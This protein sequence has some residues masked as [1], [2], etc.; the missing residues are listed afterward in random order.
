ML[1]LLRLRFVRNQGHRK[2]GLVEGGWAVPCGQF[3]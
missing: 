1:E 3:P 2:G